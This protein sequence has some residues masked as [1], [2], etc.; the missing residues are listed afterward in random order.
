MVT[1]EDMALGGEH[2]VQYIVLVT[3]KH[4]PETF[5][6]ILISITPIQLIKNLK[7]NKIVQ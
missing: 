1:G 6:I 4:T 3:L 5:M 7:I 2:T